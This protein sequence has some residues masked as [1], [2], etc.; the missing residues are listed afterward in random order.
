M[1]S[2]AEAAEFTSIILAV[3]NCTEKE[4]YNGK[5][6]TYEINRNNVYNFY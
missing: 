3:A 1:D 5:E 6:N 2:L 4:K